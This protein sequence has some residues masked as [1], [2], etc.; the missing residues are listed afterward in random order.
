[1]DSYPAHRLLT[2]REITRHRL[3]GLQASKQHQKLNRRSMAAR[4][5]WLLGSAPARLLCLLRA[6]LVALGS[7][8]LPG[9]ASGARASRLQTPRPRT[10]FDHRL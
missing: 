3:R 9:T 2:G 1:M 10:A 4:S 5:K 7:S 8:V 6:R